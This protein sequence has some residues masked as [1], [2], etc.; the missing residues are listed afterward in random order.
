[1]LGD[2]PLL[3]VARPLAAALIGVVISILVAA[4][5]AG[6]LPLDY[7]GRAWVYTG[8]VVYAT[9]NEPGDAVFDKSVRKLAE[10]ANVL[11]Y[12]AQYL[13]EE[14]EARKRGWGHSHWREAVNLVIVDNRYAGLVYRDELPA[15]SYPGMTLP[16]YLKRVREDGKLD[17]TLR[18][19][20]AAGVAEAKEAILKTLAAN[21]GSLPLHDNS[22]PEEIRR[23]LGMS[24][25]TFK[26]AVGGLYKEG[27]VKLT[28]G[29]IELKRP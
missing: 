6:A 20:G 13:P 28:A 25:K 12:D 29:S 5:V 9:D 22:A 14:Y 3:R 27:M 21:D 23:I 15:G 2:D 24:K 16:G 17:I 11:I 19:E 7:D 4:L 8:S 1:M 10:G 18:R 26:K